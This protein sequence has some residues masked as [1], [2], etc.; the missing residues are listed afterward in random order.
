[1]PKGKK[2]TSWG[3]VSR[4]Y[5]ELIERGDDTYQKKVILPNLLRAM[6]IRR[7]D[8]V[9]DVGCGQGFFSRAFVGEG[10]RVTGIDISRELI[11]LA[12]SHSPRG[13]RFEVAPADRIP[14]VVAASMDAAVSVLAVQNIETVDGMFEE[15]ARTLK[16]SGRLYLVLNHPAFRIPRGSSWGWD[17]EQKVQYRRVNRYL[18]ESTVPIQMHPGSLPHVQ[19]VSFHRSL[20][21]YFKKLAK[22]GF[23]VVR[24]EEWISHKKSGRGPRTSAEDI[25]RK[26][27]PLFMLMEAVRY[28]PPPH[29]RT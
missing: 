22:Y 15:A 1:M 12:R 21:W 25:A 3:K 8:N 19:T 4:W 13:I 14:Q 17:E 5:D 9:L 20:Q 27:I 7:G 2:K 26:E 10:A 16:S 29:S 24:L 23:A 28:V 6:R 18:S 11:A